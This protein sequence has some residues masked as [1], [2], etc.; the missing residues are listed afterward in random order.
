MTFYADFHIHSHFSIATSK[1][2]CP[3]F[4]DYWGKIKGI[5]V[6]GTGDFTHPGWLAELREKLIPAEDGLF[7]LKPEQCLDVDMSMPDAPPDVRFMLTAEISNIY[8]RD[9]K[10]RKVHNVVFA[11]DFQTAEAIQTTLSGYGFNITSDGR[12]ILG[13]DS[14]DLL[15]ICLDA[16]EDIFFVPAHIWTPWFSALG[17]KSGFDTI[18][19]CYGD[20]RTHIHAVETG[21]SSDPSMNRRCSFLDPYKLISNSDAH[22]PE[23]LG[24][25]ANRFE[26]ECDYKS[27]TGALTRDS[28][29]GFLGTVEFYPQEGKYHFDGHRK[30]GVCWNPSETKAHHGVCPVC[31]KRVTVGVMN[32]VMQLADREIPDTEISHPPYTSM[33]PLKEL[34]GELMRVGPA[35]K[36]VTNAYSK[37]I[38]KL[39]PEYEV[40][41]KTAEED[42]RK[43]CG[44]M[45]AEGIRRIRAG[46]VFIQ[47]GFDGEFGII[48]AFADHEIRHPAAQISVFKESGEGKKRKADD[49]IKTKA[50]K[51]A[52]RCLFDAPGGP[53]SV[54][55]HVSDGKEMTGELDEDQCR[56]VHHERGPALVLAGPGTG[57]TRV[58]TMHIHHLIHKQEI[59][60]DRILAVTFTN[61]AANEMKERLDTLLDDSSI[62]PRIA[63]FHGLGYA[64]L[65]DWYSENRQT[66]PLVILD[67]EDRA[68]ILSEKLGYGI[69]KSRRLLKV[70]SEIKQHVTESFE[71]EENDTKR[72]F[73]RYQEYLEQRNM[74][75]L[76][77]MNYRT[78]RLLLEN[79]PFQKKYSGLYDWIHIDEYQDINETQYRMIRLMFCGRTDN[80]FVIGDP[81]QAIY[82]F[83]G[84]N[85]RYI[86][87]FLEDYPQA[88]VY[89]LNRSYRCS[90]RILNASRQLF[91]QVSRNTGIVDGVGTGV[92]IEVVCMPT[93]KSEAEFIAR[94]IE[95]MMGGLRFF[96]MDSDIAEGDQSGDIESLSDFAVLCRTSAQMNAI[97]EAFWNHSIPY[98]KAGETPF[99]RNAPVKD[100]L[101]LFRLNTQP[102]N[103]C[104]K[105]RLMRKGFT[106]I[107]SVK[108]SGRNGECETVVQKLEK[109]IDRMDLS[110]T[111]ANHRIFINRLL[112][113][114]A[115]YRGDVSGFLQFVALG[116]DSDGFIKQQEAVAL[117]TIHGAKGLEFPCVFIAGCEDGLIPFHLY[118]GHEGDM[119]E[120]RRLLYVGM[121]RA[122]RYLFLTHAEKRFLNGRTIQLVRTPFL[123]RIEEA[124]I[125]RQQNQYRKKI[126]PSDRQMGLFT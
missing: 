43:A 85:V 27:I 60:P 93:E 42:I 116:R 108:M 62:R 68:H 89:R 113:L 106:I 55:D 59:C 91:P 34:L 78:C 41:L 4:L 118:P 69:T 71:Q 110:Q 112:D 79:K 35:S 73:I 83:R 3:E 121:T 9:G 10:V 94:T 26:T 107:D 84:A 98:Q 117:M 13:L 67:D 75:D 81:D 109:I 58:L 28:K 22:S 99:F 25:E 1:Q 39:G 96:S 32:R 45:L 20:L 66:A 17:S 6:I 97:E 53:A 11:P 40:L 122:M 82:G 70:I 119:E 102:E 14:R 65:S 64:M 47:E 30:C 101:D 48:R 120:E 19:D 77:D 76:D 104:L 123:D 54:Q 24:R 29:E 86:H 88:A 124:L 87:S 72:A 44:D 46:E 49:I 37:I 21:L 16:S 18:E 115:R 7:R 92:K 80:I 100:V 63:T 61:R 125:V 12:P 74:A 51:A 31:G 23:K 2:L 5:R 90:S 111:E 126:K 56:A 36:S 95:R 52:E 50:A 57:K 38:G 105:E 8:K 33:I 114:A 15:G 103:P